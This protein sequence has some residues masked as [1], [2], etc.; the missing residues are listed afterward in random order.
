MT[1]S[2]SFQGSNR[3]TWVTRGRSG[4]TPNGVRTPCQVD[5][6]IGAFFGLSGSIEGGMNA[7]TGPCT[8]GWTYSSAVK[9]AASYRFTMGSKKSQTGRYGAERSMWQRQIHLP[10]RRELSSRIWRS[11]AGCGSWTTTTSKSSGSSAA[12]ACIRSQ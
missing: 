2:G 12:F 8:P 3:E 1:P 5:S 7:R 10:L 9:M 6:I 4:S 11:A